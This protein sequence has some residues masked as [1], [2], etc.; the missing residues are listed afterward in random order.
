MDSITLIEFNKAGSAF[1]SAPGF[2]VVQQNRKLDVRGVYLAS[3]FAS[4]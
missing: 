2:F 3:G 1:D 4:W